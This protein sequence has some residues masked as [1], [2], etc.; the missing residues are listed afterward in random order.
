MANEEYILELRNI[1]KTFPGVR[2]LDGMNLRLRKGTVHVICGENGAGKSVMMKIINGTLKPDSGEIWYK[3]KQISNY[4]VHDSL[5]M[6][7]SMI[8]QELNPVLEMTVAENIYLGRE[9][10]KGLLA[11]FKKMNRDAAELLKRMKMPYRPEQKMKSI[12]LAGHQEIEIAKAMSVNCEVLIM[13]EP[14]SSLTNTEV[15]H[16]FERVNELRAQG[17]AIIYITHRMEEIFRLADDITIIRDGSFIESGPVSEYDMDKIVSRMVG[18]PLTN[19]YPPREEGTEFGEVVLEGRHLTQEKPDGGRFQDVSFQVRA[20][21]ILGFAGLMGAG[22]SEVMRA[23]F[24]LDPLSSG[25]VLLEGKPVKIRDTTDAVKQGMAMISEDRR[26]YGL[27]LIRD[28]HE[29]IS[30]VNLKKYA[31]HGLINDK[32]IVEE[33]NDYVNQLH[34]KIANLNVKAGTL[35]GGNQ[36]KVVIAKWLSGDVK[37]LIFDEPTRGID[38][39]AKYEIYALMRKFAKAGMAIIMISSE[40]PEVMGMSDR[41]MVMSEGRI[42][43]EVTGDDINQEKIMT[44]ALA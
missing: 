26:E 22:R 14:T 39:G 29:N 10:K 1:V 23:I 41:I 20:G 13:D 9:P 19:I 21:E 11:D 30:L 8:Y 4:N 43:G 6:G 32:K 3:G 36:Q 16:L 38:V 37:V 5:Q 42:S 15:E 35:S 25:E 18:R 24:G 40:M 12:S 2:A 34:I 28:I 44:L 27:V 17:V 31:P 33:A 7:I